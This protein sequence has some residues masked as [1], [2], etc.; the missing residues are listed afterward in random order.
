MNC[1]KLLLSVLGMTLV[2]VGL[3][4]CTSVNSSLTADRP[5]DEMFRTELKREPSTVNIAVEASTREVSDMLNKTVPREL[6]RG[7]AA[8]MGGSA[9]I[10]RSGPIVVTAA[11]NFLYVTV[12]ISLS[13][14]YGIFETPAMT[15][16]LRFKLNAKV[17]P[18]WQIYPEI[19]Y[20]GLSDSLARE[21]GIGPL[22]IEPRS[23]VDGIAQPVERT[24]SRLI[25]RQL[26]DRFPLRTQVAKA[27]AAAQKP[28]LLDMS[29]FFYGDLYRSLIPFTGTYTLYPQGTQCG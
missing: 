7:S 25:A 18:N 13:A 28:I 11:D 6:Y 23:I 10:S 5:K 14:S 22:T 15:T 9:R 21:V 16:R 2:A 29:A 12:P 4:S 27:W 24:L 8:S 17:T 1:R 3:S 19:Y 20:L 26:N